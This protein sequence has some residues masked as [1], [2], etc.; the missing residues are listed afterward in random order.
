MINNSEKK[1]ENKLDKPVLQFSVMCDGIATPKEMA[2]KP[3]FI[4]IFSSLLR[5]MRIPQFF[6]ANRWINGLGEHTQLLKILDPELKEISRVKEQKFSLPSR[7]HSVDLINGFLNINFAKPG[8][9]WV[10]IELDG[11][12]ALSYPLPVFEGK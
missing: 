6:I 3:V 9:Y 11:K 2:G 4:G 7:A 5:P 10:R 12:I 1:E 8:V